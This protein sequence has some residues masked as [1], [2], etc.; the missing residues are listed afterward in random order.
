MPVRW[1][2]LSLKPRKYPVVV[3]G[4]PVETPQAAMLLM[5]FPLELPVKQP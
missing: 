1:N 3:E 5:A 4:L 2:N